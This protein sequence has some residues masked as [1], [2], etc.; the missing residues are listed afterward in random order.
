MCQILLTCDSWKFIIELLTPEHMI[1][2]PDSSDS[3]QFSGVTGGYGAAFSALP[4]ALFGHIPCQENYCCVFHFLFWELDSIEC[5]FDQIHMAFYTSVGI[6]LVFRCN[7]MLQRLV[8]FFYLHLFEKQRNMFFIAFE[9]ILSALFS[10]MG[11]STIPSNVRLFFCTV[12]SSILRRI[13][14]HLN[15]RFTATYFSFLICTAQKTIYSTFFHSFKLRYFVFCF[16]YA[17]LFLSIS[18]FKSNRSFLF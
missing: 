12:P 18:A 15:L 16:D 10:N 5:I 11:C 3:L 14:F 2:F 6:I 8:H 4:R 13:I 1:N 17:F 7:V 9:R